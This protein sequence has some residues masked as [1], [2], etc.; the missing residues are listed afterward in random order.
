MVIT[1]RMWSSARMACIE[2]LEIG[3]KNIVAHIGVMRSFNC[4]TARAT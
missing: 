2:T 4:P 1:V 3:L